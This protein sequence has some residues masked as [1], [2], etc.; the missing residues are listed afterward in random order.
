MLRLLMTVMIPLLVVLPASAQE[1]DALAFQSTECPVE[2]P[3]DASID[4]GELV[5]PLDRSQPDGQEVRLA[6]A[7]IRY[8]G[9][10]PQPDPIVY[11]EGG[12][13]GHALLRLSREYDRFTPLLET[14]RDVI[15]FDQRGA[16]SSSLSFD[17]P[18]YNEA[19]R[20][21]QGMSEAEVAE[22]LNMA[23]RN[24]LERLSTT[25]NPDHF[26]LR[27]SAAD[28]EALRQGLGYDQINLFGSSYGTH[29]AQQVMR[30][31]PASVR[32]VVLD[33]AVA[34]EI[35][36]LLDANASLLNQYD[37]L[38]R[39]C[40]QDADCQSHYPDL[41]ATFYETVTQLN[42]KPTVIQLPHP[43]G[44]DPIEHPVTGGQFARIV[45]AQFTTPDA[46]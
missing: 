22:T 25:Y 13:G 45:R 33:S 14:G 23:Y 42:E 41:R 30:D 5:V 44:G 17:C 10:D 19:V 21:V 12:P 3:P 35:D 8:D 34:P 46:I 20:Q 37:R 38:F 24:C 18:E 29:L 6:V 2:M 43:A 4:C 15:V 7:I 36:D 16:G 28:V 11:L 1:T 26:G 9:L 31:Y 32:S 39:A 40:E 27:A